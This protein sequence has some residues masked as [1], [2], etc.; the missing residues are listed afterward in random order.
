MKNQ[1]Q[2]SFAALAVLM[3]QAGAQAD[4]LPLAALA[5][6]SSAESALGTWSLQGYS[7]QHKFPGLKEA[8]DVEKGEPKANLAQWKVPA[9]TASFV[10]KEAT[11]GFS[12]S[13]TVFKNG[14]D[15]KYNWM[16]VLLF[17]PK[18]AGGYKVTG[19]LDLWGKG[20]PKQKVVA[21][22]VFRVLDKDI[23]VVDRESYETPEAVDLSSRAKLKAVKVAEGESLAL[24]VWHP[25]FNFSSGGTLSDYEI[26]TATPAD[27]AA[28]EAALKAEAA[29]AKKAYQDA[30]AV[31]L[32]GTALPYVPLA[33]SGTA[34]NKLGTFSLMGWGNRD[35]FPDLTET[36][37]APGQGTF[38]VE[39]A[40]SVKVTLKDD[41]LEFFTQGRTNWDKGFNWLPALV[42]KPKK[43]GT[44]ALSGLLSLYG[45]KSAKPEKPDA[46]SFAVFKVKGT[47]VTPVAQQFY[48]D[49]IA[50]DL[51]EFAAADGT[52][53]LQS[54][55]LGEGESLALGVWRSAFHYEG[56]GSLKN[57]EINLVP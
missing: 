38:S 29:A 20:F 24:A 47:T 51:K 50:L 33:K 45:R 3:M 9:G 49:K 52:K 32:A 57:L 12:M 1:Y 35:K 22:A 41:S 53:P 48:A 42:F 4:V 17:K 39:G 15:A 56:G 31:G 34:E 7:D 2:L 46:V 27:I 21:W 8:Q 43:P 11:L 19:K 13:G 26:N 6:K 16:P 23:T 25:S 55:K 14:W 10:V 44:Y 28:M 37:E 54:I 18:T 36:A 40:K 5:E 30:V